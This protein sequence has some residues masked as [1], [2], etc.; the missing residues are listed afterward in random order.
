MDK[1]K[2]CKADEDSEN[3]CKKHLKV[4]QKKKKEKCVTSEMTLS[5]Q[6]S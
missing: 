3:I 4:Q 2:S 1:R 5:F 6:N